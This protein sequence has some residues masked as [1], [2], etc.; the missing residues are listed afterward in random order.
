[1]NFQSSALVALLMA[2]LQ[3]APCA[4]AQS[5]FEQPDERPRSSY[6]QRLD[7]LGKRYVHA[8]QTIVGKIAEVER[9]FAKNPNDSKLRIIHLGLEAELEN[10]RAGYTEGLTKAVRDEVARVYEKLDALT[11]ETDPAHIQQVRARMKRDLAT[12]L[13]QL[14]NVSQHGRTDL[15]GRLR[16]ASDYLKGRLREMEKDAA[17]RDEIAVALRERIAELDERIVEYESMRTIHL[18]MRNAKATGALQEEKKLELLQ[19]LKEL[20][21]QMDH[22]V[23]DTSRQ[24]Q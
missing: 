1:M 17:V 3:A 19:L 21:D 7:E 6:S 8:V 23:V 12:V 14:D 20:D 2:I 10:E 16:A 4:S 24:E 15:A 18:A 22:P 11:S 5:G 13:Q 9:Q